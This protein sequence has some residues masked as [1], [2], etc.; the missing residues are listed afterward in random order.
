MLKC[1][2]NEIDR[3]DAEDIIST[4]ASAFCT[5]VLVADRELCEKKYPKMSIEQ[6]SL[7]EIMIFYV[8]R[9]SEIKAEVADSSMQEQA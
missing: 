7:E 8:N 4:R 6:T 9:G 3:I 1:K 2:K 5:E